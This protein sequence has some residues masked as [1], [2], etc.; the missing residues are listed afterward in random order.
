[1][2]EVPQGGGSLT[3]FKSANSHLA[4]HQPHVGIV[5]HTTDRCITFV[6]VIDMS[7]AIGKQ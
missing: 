7:L 5:G 1:M 3:E 6:M 2:L 4:P